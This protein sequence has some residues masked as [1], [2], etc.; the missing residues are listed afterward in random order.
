PL[1][2]RDRERFVRA[3]QRRRRGSERRGRHLSP[4]PA[5]EGICLCPDAD[6]GRSEA[7]RGGIARQ[8]IPRPQAG[9]ERR[10]IERA[11]F[12]ELTNEFLNCET[13]RRGDDRSP[14]FLFL[15]ELKRVFFI[16]GP[17]AVG[18]SEIAAEVARRT[19][20]EVLSADAIQIYRGLDLL[21]AKPDPATPEKA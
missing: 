7:S 11:S 18:K 14:G 21:T 16:V 9:G 17:T 1:V 15:P 5:V 2:R 6:G 20:A 3:L 12:G 19:G 10:E 13:G 4:Q 8:G